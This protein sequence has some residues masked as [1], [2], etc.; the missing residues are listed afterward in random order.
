M[1][2]QPSRA[3]PITL[4]QLIALND[5]IIAL[6]RAGVPL[7]RGLWEL[8]EEMPGRLGRIAQTL[9]ERMQRGESLE[10]VLGSPSGVFPPVYRAVVQAGLKTG[11]LPAALESVAASARRLAETRRIVAVGFGYPILV[12]LLAWGLF[13]LLVTVII[14]EVLPPFESF[15]APGRWLLAELAG[16][17]ETARY[18]GPAVPAAVVVLAGVWWWRSARAALMQHGSSAVLV[19]WLP[20][21]GPMLRSFRLAAFSEVLALLVEN[22]VPLDEGILLAAE[23]AGDRRMLRS[24]RAAAAALERGETL[25]RAETV[26]Y[27]FPP[28]LRWVMGAG[29]RSGALLTALRHAAEIYRGRAARQADAARLLLPLLLTV[30]IG[31]GVTLVY[32]L[33]LF[34][35]WVVLLRSLAAG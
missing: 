22:R 6:V 11:R 15:R 24:A 25:D 33:L 12:F 19:G 18:W 29:H 34:G 28:L 20:W 9:A 3:A 5:E 8:G 23:V 10:Q 30:T 2:S 26:R 17:G 31:G 4:D 35:P 21:M 27:G 32:A 7:E 13:V 1:Q 14:P 16:W